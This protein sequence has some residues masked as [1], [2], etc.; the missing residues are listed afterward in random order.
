MYPSPPRTETLGHTE[1]YIGSWLA[2]RGDRD[3]IVLATKVSGPADWLPYLRNGKAC[4]GSA[5]HRGGGY[6]ESA[7][8][9]YRVISIFI[10][11]TGRTARPIISVSSVIGILPRIPAFLCLETLHVLGDLVAAGKVRYVGLSNET[12]WGTMRMLRLAEEHGLPQ[13]VSIQ[14]PYNLLNRTFEI[15]LAEIAIREHCGLL[16]F[17]VLSGKYL[18]GARPVGARLTQFDRYSGPRA[19][20]ATAAYVALARR[21][22]SGPGP[23]SLGLGHPSALRDH[24]YHRCHDHGSTGASP[25]FAK[26]EMGSV[27]FRVQ[28]IRRRPWPSAAHVR[29]AS[30]PARTPRGART[31]ART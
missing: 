11:S 13:P 9:A 24:R 31:P 8:A 19:A 2:A 25:S 7:A 17:G 30:V 16:A 4:T 1:R 27:R 6:G 22:G 29:P 15:G 20:Q 10:S 5:Q 28:K 18:D 14:N 26:P 21:A 23:D 3:R 12:P